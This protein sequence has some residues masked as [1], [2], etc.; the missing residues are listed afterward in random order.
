MGAVYECSHGTFMSRNTIVDWHPF[1]QYTT[2][3]TTPIPRTHVYV[4]Y[5]LEPV[6]NGTRLSYIC[7]RSY[8]PFPLRK[9]SD[10]GAGRVLSGRINAS[11]AAF[12]DYIDEEIAAGRANLEPAAS[13]A[14]GALEQAVADSLSQKQ[15]K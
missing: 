8:G 15:R 1:E 10:L 9:V 4:T 11:F 3:E 14:E 12:R 6:D 5:L 13:L 7:S 2:Y